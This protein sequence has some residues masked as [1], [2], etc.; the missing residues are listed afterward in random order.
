MNA[1]QRYK[2]AYST[3]GG[4]PVNPKMW[5]NRQDG[6]TLSYMYDFQPI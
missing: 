3:G 1:N 2:N 6:T 4:E 5:A